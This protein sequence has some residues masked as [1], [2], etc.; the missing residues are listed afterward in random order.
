MH[1]RYEKS[2]I[3]EKWSDLEKLNLWQKTEFAVLR[4]KSELLFM[5]HEEVE[6]IINIL[7]C[8]P[9]DIK[10]WKKRDKDIHHDLNAFLDE[11]L[12]HLPSNLQKYFHQDMTSYDTEEPAFVRMLH[13]SS[14]AIEVKLRSLL[15]CIASKALKYRY[16]IMNGRTHGQEAELQSLG[17]R[18]LTWYVDLKTGLDFL[19]KLVRRLIYS[20]LSGAIGNYGGITPE[21]EEKA[22]KH[23]GLKPFYGATQIMPRE[24]YAPLAQALCQIVQT[25]N[26]I[27]LSIRLGARSGNPI[28]HEP[29]AKKQKGSSAMPHK[30]N[31]IRTEQLDG[32]ANMANGYLSMIMNSI[33][34]W[35]ER[36]IEQSCVERVAWPDLFHVTLHS[37]EVMFKVLDGLVVYPENMLKEIIN[38]RGCYASSVVKEFLREK[39]V[40]VGLST[41]DTYRIVQLAA[42]NAFELKQHHEDIP[43]LANSFEEAE[44]QL[45]E[46]FHSIEYT[47]ISIKEI[48]ANSNLLPSKQ[49]EASF[50]VIQ[51]W[52]QALEG[53]F[54][55]DINRQ[56]WEMIF[57]PSYL[58]R[59]EEVLFKQILGK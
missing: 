24:L 30:K 13:S 23:L 16:T 22:L 56:E 57:K 4:A 51:G 7:S 26:K 18:Y 52:N 20:K 44:D 29:F 33:K 50:E 41:E 54:A 15:E 27:A 43:L 39:G 3:K 1:E 34:T 40:E 58:L 46:A 38:S 17:K 11:R 8:Q 37:I 12:R 53:I 5:P 32:M 19:S 14:L 21:I 2:E 47:N 48:I 25:L 10:W 55:S 6:E 28:F 45:S 31:T 36:A 35:E 59:H 42:F 9:I 49:L